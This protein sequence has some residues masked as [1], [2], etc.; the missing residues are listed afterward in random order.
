MNIQI[1]INRKLIGVI[2]KKDILKHLEKENEKK[3]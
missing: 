3:H 2:T 1:L